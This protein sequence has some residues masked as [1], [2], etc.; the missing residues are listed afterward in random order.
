MDSKQFI[1]EFGA[2][3]S[4]PGGVQRLRQMIYNLAITGQL[5]RQRAE[6]GD[7]ESL[8]R[9]IESRKK[10]LLTE[11]SF[12]RSPKLEH[13]QVIQPNNIKLPDSWR[14]SSLVNIGEINPKNEV[15][16]DTLA[17]FI[18]M[19]GVPQL[20]S[21]KLEPEKRPWGQIK[22]GFTH[23]ADGDVVLAKITP[24]FE[25]GKA[26][27]ITGLTNG[28]GAGTTELHV[29]RALSGF[30]EPTYIYLFLRSP[31]FA[32]DGGSHM[33]G[34]AGQKRLPV[35]YFA[36]RAF[37][38][39][40]LAEQQR[41][42]ARVEGLMALCD[43]LERE[44]EYRVR[45]CNRIRTAVLD[46]LSNAHTSEAL[47][48]SW[49]RLQASMS[50]LVEQSSDV[51]DLRALILDL[52]ATGRLSE[53]LSSDSKAQEMIDAAKASRLRL[54]AAREMKSKN[55]TSTDIKETDIPIPS[56]W[57]RASMDELFRFID[58]RGKT[59]TKTTSGRV[60]I[61]AKN[62]RPG[63]V[64]RDPVE[65]VSE[66]SYQ[67]WMTRGL[68]KIGDLLITTEAPLGNVA[69]LEQEPHFALAQR[70]IDLQPFARM[71]ARYFMYF[72]MSPPFQG[73][74]WANA[75]G[76]TAKGIKAAKLKRLRLSVP[77]YEEQE[78]IVQRTESL[79]S[80]CDQLSL[81]L[82]RSRSL[83]GQL[84]NAFTAAVTSI[85]IEDKEKMKAP[86]TELVS[87]LRIGIT[88]TSRE[89]APL[90][91]ILVRHQ[92]ELPAKTL[93]GSSGMEIDHFYQQLKTEMA[94]GWIVQ[95]AVAYMKD[96][97]TG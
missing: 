77:P 85:R 58:Y 76:M 19:S 50:M 91:T 34:T 28:I 52:A 70:V 32:V 64:A 23:F 4:A 40:P 60:L 59:P 51:D 94:R 13:H 74:L 15:A 81:Q 82:D 46:S 18:P 21:G 96:V 41:I 11:K 88:P 33:T 72:I 47:G 84:A 35:E 22:K 68:P 3:A 75:T 63:Y 8:L 30:I 83:A 87:N 71:K 56:H 42:V 93:W 10:R 45:L 55:A 9:S 73:L 39:P 54:I 57:A 25:N 36:T 86:K 69:Q 17:S 31:Y 24:C 67:A 44:Q 37:P 1:A 89:Q 12:K 5:T 7:A 92:G 20:H 16:D 2:I 80:W 6:D 62:V 95:P 78:R 97:E 43:K 61:T 66:A 79:L 27:V 90:A 65:Y 29:V 26:A 49:R 48:S 38:L 14:W 53:S